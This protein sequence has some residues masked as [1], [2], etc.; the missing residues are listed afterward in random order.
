MYISDFARLG[1]VSMRMLRHYDDL[2]LL[3]PDHVDPGNG[4]RS[5]SPEQLHVLNRLV[6][7]KDLGFT[8]DQVRRIMLDEVSADE[9]RGMLRLRRIELEDEARA[10][11]TR[12]MAVESRLRMIEQEN[13]MSA[14]YV[15]KSLPAVRLVAAT[16]TLDPDHLAEHIGPMFGAV[17][18]QLGSTP[19]ALASPIATYSLTDSGMDVVVGYAQAGETPSRTT[20]IDLPAAEV[21]CGVHLGSMATIGESWQALHRWIAENGYQFAGPCREL[22]VRTESDDQSTWVTELQQPI[23]RVRPSAGA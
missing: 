11:G 5:Y 3:T 7:L 22:Y 13:T 12:L 1:Q 19:A 18:A 2:G 20:T 10:I 8:L 4:Y 21:V 14:D 23:L 15:I 17:A 6:A 9:L 16:A